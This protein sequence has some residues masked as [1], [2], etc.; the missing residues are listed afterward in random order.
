MKM[1]SSFLVFAILVSF[2]FASANSSPHPHTEPK[3]HAEEG[4]EM[5][6]KMPTFLPPMERVKDKVEP[7]LRSN[8][9]RGM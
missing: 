8:L 1:I 5:E 9:I 6:L 7:Q 3:A 2:N 4:K